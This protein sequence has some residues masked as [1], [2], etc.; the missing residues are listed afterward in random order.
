M[1]DSILH[2]TTYCLLFF[3][4]IPT[5]CMVMYEYYGHFY[6]GTGTINDLKPLLVGV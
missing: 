4:Y 3:N 5:L 2:F 6:C 1:C